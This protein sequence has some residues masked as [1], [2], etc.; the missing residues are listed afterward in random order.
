MS[1]LSLI[2]CSILIGVFA[3]KKKQRTGAL[4]GFLTFIF[5]L[6]L[7]AFMNI[8]SAFEP[9]TASLMSSDDISVQI[10]IGMLP[11]IIMGLI[12]LTLPQRKK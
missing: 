12:V 6:F 2:I 8:G 9:E 3:Q 11:A 1:G 7:I 5:G 10:S 4:W